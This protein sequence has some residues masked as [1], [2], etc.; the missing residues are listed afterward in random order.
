M[1][2]GWLPCRCGYPALGH[3]TFLC[4]HVVDERECGLMIYVPPHG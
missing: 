3:R 2:I 4:L 1:L